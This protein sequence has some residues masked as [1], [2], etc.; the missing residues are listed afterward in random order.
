MQ[1]MTYNM[2]HQERYYA[3]HVSLLDKADNPQRKSD[4]MNPDSI[5]GVI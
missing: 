3:I 5:L 2:F 1:N 4:L